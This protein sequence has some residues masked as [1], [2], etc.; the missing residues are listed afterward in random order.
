MGSHSQA[1]GGHDLGVIVQCRT[2]GNNPSASQGGP[3]QG[4]T[5]MGS[6]ETTT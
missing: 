5:E 6:C 3:L 1:A 4:L 2:Q